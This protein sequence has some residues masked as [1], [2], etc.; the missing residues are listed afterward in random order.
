MASS[1]ISFSKATIISFSVLLSAVIAVPLMKR[2]TIT[3]GNKGWYLDM[4]ST[5]ESAWANSVSTVCSKTSTGVCIGESVVATILTAL[6]AL[7]NTGAESDS[8][9]T[10]D[11]LTSAVGY[12][13]GT[14]SSVGSDGTTT[15]AA[16]ATTTSGSP[17]VATSAA[18]VNVLS[19]ILSDVKAIPTEIADT[20]E[21]AGLKLLGVYNL[22]NAAKTLAALHNTTQTVEGDIKSRISQA[23]GSVE[24]RAAANRAKIQ[25][26][27]GNV[28][29]RVAADRTKVQ[30][31]AGNVESRVADDSTKLQSILANIAGR[32]SSENDKIKSDA[33]NIATHVASDVA[34]RVGSAAKSE[35]SHITYGAEKVIDG[36][37]STID[38]VLHFNS[39][40]GQHLV[41]AIGNTNLTELADLV[42]KAIPGVPSFEKVNEDVE[43]T[44]ENI[45]DKVKD[46]AKDSVSNLQT[47]ISNLESKISNDKTNVQSAIDNVKSI[48]ESAAK[49]VESAAQNTT[50]NAVKWISYNIQNADHDIADVISQL[51]TFNVTKFSNEISNYVDNLGD[52]KFCLSPS[53]GYNIS[54][55]SPSTIFGEIYFN[56]YGGVENQCQ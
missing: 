26:I 23:A 55:T 45:A 1:N 46:A 54:Y 52:F 42:S 40:L 31:I 8:T 56:T 25:S 49:N 41:T 21:N 28:E 4:T 37:E 27:V 43:N 30:S 19:K 7:G 16:P 20:F 36:V 18:H 24:S 17:T 51:P 12:T 48:A 11:S 50:Q 35:A 9:E 15:I 13:N 6:M 44:V 32:V 5:D 38:T 53:T 47:A 14:Q 22:T 39:S 29:S 33:R 34:S 10:T 3:L 2:D